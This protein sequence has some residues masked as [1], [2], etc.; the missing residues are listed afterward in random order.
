MKIIRLLIGLL[1]LV[2]PAAK[3]QFL[4]VTNNGVAIITGYDGPGGAVTIPSTLGG[5]PVTIIEGS[6]FEDKGITSV[7]ISASV[8]NIEPQEFAPNDSLTSFTVD[9]NNPAYSATNGVLF[10]KGATT[11]V[12]Y[13]PGVAGSY[14]I[15]T[16][17]TTIGVSAFSACYYVNGLT[18]PNSVTNLQPEAFAFCFGLNTVTIPSSV[19]SIGPGAFFNCSS[20]TN[21]AV[22]PGNPDFSSVGGVLLYGTTL[23]EYPVGLSGPYTIPI[24]VTTIGSNAFTLCDTLTGV[25]MAPSVTSLEDGCFGDCSG[26]TNLTLGA[27]VSY[28]STSA[29][30]G[31]E[32]LTAINVDPANPNFSS[33]DG[34]VFNKNQT[35]LVQFPPGASAGYTTPGTV[36]SIA[37]Y[38]FEGCKLTD[39]IITSNVLNVGFES[40]QGCGDLTNV[41]M[42]EGVETIGEVAFGDCP[43]LATVTIPA[44]VS[45]LPEY[46]FV[47]SGLTDIYFEGN[48]P[49]SDPQAFFGD[50]SA[51]IYFLAGTS[52]WGTTFDG[53]TTV[54]ENEP[55]SHGA[56]LVTILPLGAI[57]AGAQWQVDGGV[58]QPSGAIVLGLSGG[59]HTVSFTTVNGW[60]AP[61]NEMLS[62]TPNATNMATGTYS[63]EVAPAVDFTFVTN[64]GSITITGYVGPP[65]FVNMPATITGLPV[66]AIAEEAF[67]N[68]STI[69]SMTIA[70][71]VTNL[72][73]YAFSDCTGLTSVT[74]PAGISNIATGAFEDC[75]ALADVQ[76]LGSLTDI[77][78]YAFSSCP[79]LTGLTI[80]GTVTNIGTYAFFGNG[81]TNA[82]IPSSVT[83]IGPAAFLFCNQLPAITVDPANPSY[84]S[85]A[86]VLFNKRQTELVE[87]P[88]GNLESSYTITNSVTSIGDYAFES[89]VLTNVTIPASVTNIGNYSFESCSYLRDI[90]IPGSVT[91]IGNETFAQCDALTGIVIPA[92]VTTLGQVP[93]A[94]CLNMTAFTVSS[95]NPAFAS[96]NG[97]LYNKSG[98]LLVEFPGGVTGDFAIPGGV[99]DVGVEAFSGCAITGVTIPGSVTNIELDGFFNCANLGSATMADGLTTLGVGAFESCYALTNVTLPATLAS[100]GFSAFGNCSVL[101][102]IVIPSAVKSVGDY[103]FSSDPDLTSAYFEG[104]APPDDSTVFSSDGQTTVYYLP[105]ATGWGSTFGTAPTRA[106]PGITITA[107]PTNGVVP[108]TVSFTAAATNSQTNL[109]ANWNWSFGDGSTT[110]EQ[111]PSHTYSSR[112]IFAAA[113]VQTNGAGVPIAGEVA[114]ITVTPEPEFLGLVENGGF[115]TGDFTG[116][117]LFGGDTKDNY[118]TNTQSPVLPYSGSYFAVL[119]S[120]GSNLTYL[121]QSLATTAG[122]PY[123]LSLW[124]NSP[125]GLG[126]NQ[127]TVSWNGQ[128]L[129][130]QTN[131][132]ALGWTN[133]VFPVSA[134]G[135]NTLL[136]LGFRDDPSFLGLDDI[137]VYPA[138]PSI[139][140][141]SVAGI[142]LVLDG[143]NGQSGLIYVVLMS[144]NLTLPLNRWTPTATNLLSANGNFSITLTNTVSEKIPQRF[145]LLQ[146]Q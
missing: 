113:V 123:W 116:W 65:G 62:V 32:N 72:G 97:V 111:N 14:A 56:L 13:P 63:V 98:T 4:Y 132:P 29:F 42:A 10:N 126:P 129:F 48:E 1:L 124:L 9:S 3:A 125:D 94:N 43:K 92:S 137:S 77:G 87:Y 80:S 78:D 69:T 110:E 70:N 55:N 112:G 107:H 45:Y 106:L 121:S 91:S 21:I 64:A 118:V 52:G 139:A 57:T 28:F 49:A 73:D 104:N 53:L 88:D 115:E 100:F 61:S 25:T 128:M 79:A 142:N 44:S 136:E 131:L 95:A 7:D 40:F 122:E 102:G 60:L 127:F 50:T 67:A 71:S 54:I 119:G 105:G 82:Q 81:L 93:F 144:T 103:A 18:I 37:D 36:T 133:L 30:G 141:V 12:E 35:V 114:T 130:N 23:L 31:A 75:F 96:V 8:T 39:A 108:L 134:A 27:G 85:V 2:A 135:T 86:G 76:I 15:P 20:L 5:L 22:S 17:V 6:G 140:S 11:L 101:R 41:T 146:T 74:I 145:Y 26:L 24:G 47:Y 89:C 59:T 99:G 58:L 68:I 33:L 117:D 34:V 38:A 46:A 16:N 109:V 83:N 66:T 90:T 120:V 19:I 51:T 84:T 143:V 138:Y